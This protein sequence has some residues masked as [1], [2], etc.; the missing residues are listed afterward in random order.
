MVFKWKNWVSRLILLA[1]GLCLVT[2]SESEEG[3]DTRHT[4]NW[5]VLVSASRYWFNYRV[6]TRE[7]R[8]YGQ[9]VDVLRP[10]ALA[11]VV[12]LV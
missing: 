10:A 9:L 12:F 6:S 5:A 11:V 1:V 3:G 7:G 4:N 2:A 8:A